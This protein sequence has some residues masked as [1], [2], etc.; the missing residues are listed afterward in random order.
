MA[1]FGRCNTT[2]KS[3][4]PVPRLRP[5]SVSKKMGARPSDLPG[6]S[7]HILSRFAPCG[8]PRSGHHPFFSSHPGLASRGSYSE[9]SFFLEVLCLFSQQ[10]SQRPCA[11]MLRKLGLSPNFL[12]ASEETFQSNLTKSKEIKM[13]TKTFGR[14]PTLSALH[15]HLHQE[16][17]VLAKT[18]TTNRAFAFRMLELAKENRRMFTKVKQSEKKHK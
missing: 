3:P 9:Q 14:F 2:E 12:K 6:L 16:S 15:K 1:R 18:F 8:I 10:I 13:G 11:L 17:L 5:S 7:R 4:E